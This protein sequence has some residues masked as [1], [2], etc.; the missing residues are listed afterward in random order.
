MPR[1]PLLAANWKMN[2]T[3]AEATDF[4]ATFLDRLPD[5]G[6]EVVICPPFTALEVA[7]RATE[8]SRVMIAAQNMHEARVG[9]LHGR[10][11]GGDAD[12]ARVEAV[13]LGHSERRQLFGETDEALARKVPAALAA[14]LTPILCVGED[15]AQREADETAD[16]LTTQIDAGLS[17]VPSDELA[18]V[19]V[20]YE[21]IWAIGTGATATPETAQEAAALIR[22]RLSGRSTEAA[23]EVRVLYGGSVKPANAGE[24]MAA[25]GCGRRARRR[26]EP[27]GRATSSASWKPRAHE[28]PPGPHPSAFVPAAGSEMSVGSVALVVLDGWGLAPD[29]PGNAVSQ[30]DT[31]VFDELWATFPHTTLSTSGRDVGL[32]PGQMG[33]SEVGHLNL[34]AGRS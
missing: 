26:G 5:N 28:A 4:L 12:R 19:V 25:A 22:V 11:L 32:P 34:G 3:V 10:G 31:P 17:E 13:V 2:K 33:N 7:G 20:A 1:T 8:E 15:Q 14:G 6:T 29:G 23:E 9:R 24:L 30:A 21:P 16:V 27:R 18:K